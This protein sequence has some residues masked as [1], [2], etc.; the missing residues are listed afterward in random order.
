MRAGR[1]RVLALFGAAA[2]ARVAVAEPTK[3][4][5]IVARRFEFVPA[6]ITVARGTRLTLAVKA[7]DFVHGFSMPDFGIRKDTVP[8]QFLEVTITPKEPGRYH[9]LCDNF[10]GED[11]DKMGGILIVT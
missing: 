7:I 11:H 9:F 6:E 2:I 3:R 5:E 8:G 1:R 10:C 4:I